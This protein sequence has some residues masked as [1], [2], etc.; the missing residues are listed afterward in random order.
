VRYRV[1]RVLPRIHRNG[2]GISKWFPLFSNRVRIT[3]YYY[4]NVYTRCIIA[5][6]V[7]CAYIARGP[8]RLGPLGGKH[9]LNGA[10]PMQRDAYCTQTFF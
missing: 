2:Y 3:Q 7:D 5:A 4:Y 10:V 8:L 6:R 9:L 1:Y